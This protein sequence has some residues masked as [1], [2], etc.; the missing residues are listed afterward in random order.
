MVVVKRGKKIL[1]FSFQ[2]GTI[3]EILFITVFSGK[4]IK[5]KSNGTI[6]SRLKSKG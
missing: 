3:K 6:F 4:N 1:Y 2:E 5:K